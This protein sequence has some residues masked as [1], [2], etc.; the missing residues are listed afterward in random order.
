[1][2]NP[3][4]ALS[5]FQNVARNEILPYILNWSVLFWGSCQNVHRFHSFCICFKW[6]FGQLQNIHIPSYNVTR[7]KHEAVISLWFLRLMTSL[8]MSKKTFL[9]F[10]NMLKMWL[11]SHHCDWHSVSLRLSV[12][13]FLSLLE[14]TPLLSS[15]SAGKLLLLNVKSSSIS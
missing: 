14:L 6:T 15:L 13:N 9:E 5:Y 11:E 1:M 7:W 10:E 2:F 3:N 8:G 12:S 4:A